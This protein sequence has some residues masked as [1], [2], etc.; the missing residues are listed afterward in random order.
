MLVGHR[1]V[2]PLENQGRYSLGRGGRDPPRIAGT[3][4]IDRYAV[5]LPYSLGNR[6]GNHP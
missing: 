3:R 6:E 1:V 2:G 5:T 4:G